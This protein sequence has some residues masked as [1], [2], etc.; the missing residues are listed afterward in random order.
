MDVRSDSR[1]VERFLN[2]TDKER[3]EGF[4][5]RSPNGEEA[6]VEE[7]I[8]KEKREC[9]RSVITVVPPFSVSV[10]L[11][12]LARLLV[13]VLTSLA[14]GGYACASILHAF[15]DRDGD[16]VRSSIVNRRIHSSQSSYEESRHDYVIKRDN[17]N[18]SIYFSLDSSFALLYSYYYIPEFAFHL[19]SN[20]LPLPFLSVYLIH[21]LVCIPSVLEI[22][23]V[24]LLQLFRIFGIH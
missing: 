10:S 12:S 24:H 9:K 5:Q 11:F 14:S 17:A 3:A 23:Y 15:S 21:A 1:R 2:R 22:L 13:L 7:L 4:V 8:Q 6:S 19:L 16:S 18:V 20:S